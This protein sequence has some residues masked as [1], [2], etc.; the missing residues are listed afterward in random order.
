MTTAEKKHSN[1][2]SAGSSS[3]IF[4][5]VWQNK[6]FP[7]AEQQILATQLGK[8]IVEGIKHINKFVE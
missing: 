2:A 3:L 1:T 5:D 7:A 8:V 4:P 6:Q